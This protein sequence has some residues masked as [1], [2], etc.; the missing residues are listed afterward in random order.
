MIDNTLKRVALSVI[1][2]ILF[3]GTLYSTDHSLLEDKASE[4]IIWAKK[5]PSMVKNAYKDVTL[6]VYLKKNKNN[7]K[8]YSESFGGDIQSL[9][10]SGNLIYTIYPKSIQRFN[11]DSKDQTIIRRNNSEF[12]FISIALQDN[13]IHELAVKNRKLYSRFDDNP[14]KAIKS[15]ANIHKYSRIL[16]H[17]EP[18]QTVI[19]HL[20]RKGKGVVHM[21][22]LMDGV[23]E[24]TEFEFENISFN[25]LSLLGNDLIFFN[26]YNNKAYKNHSDKL[27][28]Y[29][30]PRLNIKKQKL[31]ALSGPKNAPYTL[32]RDKEHYYF[33]HN[34]E[35]E[36]ES[37]PVFKSSKPELFDFL[38]TQSLHFSILTLSILGF[39]QIRKIHQKRLA[40]EE[41]EDRIS[42]LFFRSLAFIIDIQ[43]IGPIIYLLR[44]FLIEDNLN[45]IEQFTPNLVT[46]NP[47]GNELYDEQKIILLFWNVFLLI[48]IH[49][50]V[51]VIYHFIFE[52]FFRASLGKMFFQLVLKSEDG[53]DVTVKQI[54]IK[55]LCRF[56]DYI[57]IPV[58]F[59]I[60]LCTDKRQ[61]LGDLCAKTVIMSKRF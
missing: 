60:C 21:L 50:V 24:N 14:W 33:K 35:K 15:T 1:I 10:L 5:Q 13:I 37:T 3:L 30:L 56:I 58:G 31:L 59:I 4:Y 26:S 23:I 8:T 51:F 41:G 44:Y 36:A 43:I 2:S 19:T 6:N 48:I 12:S 57:I 49:Q 40:L 25:N 54:A 29:S 47:S 27:T 9:L 18:D 45:A 28:P 53:S 17:S 61:T 32:S 46:F 11:L 34:Q 55:S 22:S 38:I 7:E 39:I 20:K 16:V 42:P 52:Y